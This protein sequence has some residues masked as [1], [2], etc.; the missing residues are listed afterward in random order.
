MNIVEKLNNYY[1]ILGSGSPRRSALFKSVGLQFGVKS[2]K[3]NEKINAGCSAAEAAVILSQQKAEALTHNL[4][5][6]ENMVLVTADTVVCPDDD[7]SAVFGKPQ[8]ESEAAA[9]LNR[10]SASSHSVYT[11]VTLYHS[12]NHLL[13]FTEKTTVFFR[14][15]SPEAISEYIK[16]GVPFD[17]AG[18]YGIQDAFG[19]IYSVKIEGDYNNVLG[20]PMC[21]F[22]SECESLLN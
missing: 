6:E 5:P 14:D 15:I 13:S 10:L 7:P 12:K 18:A 3:I 11:A 21:R 19:L 1:L 2:A 8:T 17:R 22:L 16:S 4:L 9:M 20:F